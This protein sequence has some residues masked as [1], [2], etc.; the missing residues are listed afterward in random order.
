LVHFRVR[1]EVV[2]GR[3]FSFMTPLVSILIPAYNAEQ[4]LAETV[5]SALNQTW[6]RKEIIIVDD[7]SRDGTLALAR[8]FESPIVKVVTHPNQGA[9]AT[10]N[11]AYSLSQGD[12][13]QWLDA[14]D[15]L[16]PN[17]VARQVE[18]GL[19]AGSRRTLLSCGWA[20]FMYR[21]HRARFVPT[22]LWE[23]LSPLE[24]MTRKLE[25]NLHMQTATWLVSR[26]LTDAAGPWNTQL[27]G[28][29][30]GE[31]FARVLM[32]SDA[33]RFVP[34]GRVYYRISPSSRLSY[35]GRNHRKMEAQL[36]SMEL[37]I[38][39]LRSVADSPR[40]RAA[41]V[42]YLSN[43]LPSFYPER[44]DLVERAQRLAASLGGEL[45]SPRL[46]WKYAWIQKLFGWPVAKQCQVRYN[47]CKASVIR[48]WD[49]MLHRL[50]RRG[51]EL[52]DGR[53]AVE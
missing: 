41:C 29:D 7:G 52:P 13:I 5:R 23:N 44:P 51:A 53:C 40:V 34:N 24:W 12:Y 21:P 15:L 6:V 20:Y 43:W 16:G 32:A 27:L 38:R 47:Q 45:S 36:H 19:A 22:P 9:A 18:E 11:K 46:P 2:S 17:K 30:D 28:D 42:T 26:E 3:T 8:Q 33:V 48:G 1:P 50:E 49:R 14:D 25:H 31:Y 35:I 39:Y 10:R 4:F 37:N